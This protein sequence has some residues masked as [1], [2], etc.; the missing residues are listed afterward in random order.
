MTYEAL[1]QTLYPRYRE[2]GYFFKKYLDRYITPHTRLLDIG[3]GHQAFGDEY[4]RRANWRVGIDPDRPALDRNSLMDEKVCCTI[5]NIPEAVGTFDVMVAQ[6]VMEHLP[7]PVTAM[8]R[9]RDLCRPGG[10]FIF[11]TTNVWSP[12][13]ALSSML[14][15]RFKKWWRRGSL[16]INEADTFP[17]SYL[18][19]TPGTIERILKT[20]SPKWPWSMWRP[21]AII[22][23]I[24]T[25]CD[26]LSPWIN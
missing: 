14:P 10:Y 12:L 8:Q 3:C 16:G 25:C 17:T 9:L 1:I 22:H 21:Y 6:W 5:E 13:I 18:M 20:V 15:T 19:N 2:V 23:S 26:W 4:Y 24:H 11:M 7:H